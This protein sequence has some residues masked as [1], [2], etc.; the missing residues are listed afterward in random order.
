[1]KAA[2]VLMKNA[3]SSSDPAAFLGSSMDSS[4]RT[5]PT[6]TGLREKLGGGLGGREGLEG[7]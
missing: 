3:A 4:F 1:M 2:A 7:E 5:S 6:K